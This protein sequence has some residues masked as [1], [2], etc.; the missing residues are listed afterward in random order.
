MVPEYSP[1]LEAPLALAFFT[2]TFFLRFYLYLCLASSSAFI[3]SCMRSNSRM[4][5]VFSFF[6]NFRLSEAGRCHL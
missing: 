6:L 2:A 4:A 3:C 5:D 1:V